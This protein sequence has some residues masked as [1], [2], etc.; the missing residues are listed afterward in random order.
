[1]VICT[2][3]THILFS[4]FYSS[5]KEL[6]FLGEKEESNYRDRVGKDNMSLK[7]HTVSENNKMLKQWRAHQKNTEDNLKDFHWPNIRQDQ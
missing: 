3:W 7:Q 1:M 6:E 5:V 4:K 2:V